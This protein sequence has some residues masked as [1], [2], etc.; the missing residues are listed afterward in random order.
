MDTIF[1]EEEE[2]DDVGSSGMEIDSKPSP[3][4]TNQYEAEVIQQYIK[5]QQKIYKNSRKV[6]MKK[7]KPPKW[8]C[9]VKNC[10]WGGRNMENMMS[11]LKKQHPDQPGTQ[12][13]VESTFL[14]NFKYSQTRKGSLKHIKRDVQEKKVVEELGQKIKDL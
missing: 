10:Q 8:I 14:T 2:I 13:A 5:E 4:P 3:A 7:Q 6:T 1:E 11:H 9:T 12:F